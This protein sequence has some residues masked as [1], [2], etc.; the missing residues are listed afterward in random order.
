MAGR[1]SGDTPLARLLYIEDNREN[2]MLVRAILEAAGY[3]IVDAEDGLSGI[4]A[5][6]REQPDLIL[7]DINLPGVDG[8]EVVSIL[9]S[10]PNLAT[11]PVIAHTAYAMEGDRQRTLVAGCDGY[12]QK[13]IDV[14]AFPRQVAEF[15]RGKREHVEAREEG[16]YL[17]ELNQRLVYRLLNQVE[18]LKR[19]NQHF[20]RRAGQLAELHRAVQDITSEVSIGDLLQT[21]LPQVARALNTTSLTVELSDPA[22]VHVSI[23]GDTGAPPR[24][25]LSGAMETVEDWVETEWKLPIAVRGRRVGTMTARHVLPPGA[26]A[27]EEQLLNIVANQLA[28]AVE[29]SRLYADVKRSYEHTEAELRTTETFLAVSQT[30]GSTLDLTEVLRRTARAM[31]RAVGADMAGAWLLSKEGDGF[32]PIVG[33]HVPKTL[34]MDFQAAP[35]TTDHAL[36]ERARALEKATYATD[37]QA[38]ARFAHPLFGLVPHKSLLVQPIWLKGENI[39]SFVLAWTRETHETTE[40]ELRLVDGIA[41]Q[42][43]VAVENARLLEAERQAQA[44][45]K[46]FVEIVKEVAAED[47]FERLFSLIG[48]R[49]CELLGADTATIWLRDGDHIE[50]RNWYGLPQPDGIIRRRPV[51]ESLFRRGI[52]ERRPFV[53]TD[54]PADPTWHTSNFT[55]LGYRAVLDAP[56]LLG[57][58]VIGVLAVFYTR[59][60]AFSDEDVSLLVSLAGH[61]AVALDRTNLVRELKGRLE[62]S[63]T[64]LAVSQ[65]VSST[66]DLTEMMRRVARSMAAVLNADMVGAYLADAD[67]RFL[68]PIAGYHVP[69]H[70]RDDVAILLRGHTF[71]EEAWTTREPVISADPA[72]DARLDPEAVARFGP[73]VVLFVPMIARDE[74]IGGFFAIWWQPA[75]PP[76]RDELRLIEGMARQAGIATENSRL[77]EG[78]KRQMAELKQTQAQ[79]IQ[80]TKLAA[81]G[82]LAANVAHEINNPLT[83]VLG[84]ASFLAE[85]LEPGAPTLEELQ[86]IQ[87]EATRARDIVRDLLQ[88]SRQSEFLPAMTEVNVVVEQVVAMVRRQGAVETI[89]VQEVYAPDLPL[90]EIDVSR[91]KQVFLN[92]MNNAIY[93]MP[94]GGRLTLSTFAHDGFVHVAFTDTGTGIEPEH[95]SRI[96]DPF[97]TTKP[98]VSGTGLGLSVSLGI[99]QSHAGTIEVSSTLGKGSTFTVKLPLDARLRA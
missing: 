89:A 28:I 46:A 48:R 34:L 37:S 86:L 5:A 43:A 49:V 78:V 41:R 90:V 1:T 31:A 15:M 11:T 70:L 25:V 96:F 3:E 10:F 54:M 53:T 29:N 62:E 30:V 36:F 93:A 91:M 17:R 75:E 50:L 71:I 51:A 87:Q 13:P 27:D 85:K 94:D 42:T 35:I 7:L 68:R 73:C 69:G 2:R 22:D 76:T 82:E 44:R 14:D 21:L 55:R 4:E 81:I 72:A 40:D 56:I 6:I 84:F 12:I 38:D 65:A 33:Y 74:P 26:K 19:L 99:V 66:L 32:M 24:S 23:A 83:T 18:E 77:Y 95:L 52:V 58:E 88:F 39:G 67:A 9:K 79:L 16:I 57:D 59:P 45:Q 64:L 8:Y 63:Q 61:T 20:V 80:S 98:D 92:I 97:F 47:K 60:R